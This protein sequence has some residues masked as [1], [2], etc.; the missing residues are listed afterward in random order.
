VGFDLYSRMLA[1]AVEEQKAKRE[2]RAPIIETPQAV[3]DLPIDAHLPTEY[4]P[5]EAQKL[6]LYRRLA[7]AR[8][9]GDL[10]A[11]RQDVADRFGPLPPAVVR[12]I[13]VAELRLAAEAAGVWSISREEGW[14]VVRFGAALSR[15]M[16]MRLLGDGGLAGVK[17]TDIVFASN[18]VRVRAPYLPTRAWG[19]TQAIVAR[20]G[21]EGGG[22]M[23]VPST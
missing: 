22:A 21:G 2:G 10:A 15:S 13:E 18:Q 9:A 3:V 11:F 12:L 19:L 14:L 1:E 8:T 23:A 7:R 6:E 17:P 4:V 20:L 5:D 16:A